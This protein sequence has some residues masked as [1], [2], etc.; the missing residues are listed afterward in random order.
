M[1]TFVIFLA[2]I[3]D[4]CRTLAL[5]WYTQGFRA[6]INE[7]L[8]LLNVP[9]SGSRYPI[10]TYFVAGEVK[11]LTPGCTGTSQAHTA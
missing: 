1:G 8:V 6:R 7:F 10:E 11:G 2:L 9:S 3:H 4:P 5:L